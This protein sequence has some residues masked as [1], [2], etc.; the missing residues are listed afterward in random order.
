MNAELFEE[1]NTLTRSRL[2]DKRYNHVLGVANTAEELAR[3]HGLPPQKT[4]LA[5]LLH[6]AAREVSPEELLESARGYGLVPDDFTKERPML[7]HGPVAAEVARRE[8][9]VKDPEV[10]EAVR[11][12][13]TGA[14]G[15]GPLTLAVYVA[16]K[17]EPG[18]DYPSVG[19]LRELAREDLREAAKA[20]LR[21]TE[22]HNENRGR[23]THPDSRRMLAWLEGSEP[24][25]E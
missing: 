22:A 11:V 10:L 6:D 24:T 1:A 4:R 19:K 13:T 21:A 18:R 9:G 3:T 7:L 5:A 15:V 12:H 17:I 16:D 14:P 20:I 2:S 25:K 23:P 8:L